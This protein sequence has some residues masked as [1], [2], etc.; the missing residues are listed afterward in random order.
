[1]LGSPSLSQ[2]LTA[3]SEVGFNFDPRT[4]SESAGYSTTDVRHP[5]PAEAPGDPTPGGSWEISR[6]LISDYAFADPSTVRAHYDTSAPL[7][8]R[9]MVLELRALGVFRVF[10]GVRIIEVIDETREVDGRP[11]RVWGWTYGTLR[12]HVES[13]EMSWQTW[14]WLDSGDVEFR[15]HALSRPSRIR[16]PFTAVGFRVV[17][18]HERKTFLHDAGER[19][20]RLIEQRLLGPGTL[21]PQPAIGP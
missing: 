14:K 16:N 7:M 18:P 15:V 2:R 17:G 8:G 19:L 3:L 5:L 10:V 20:N 1:M 21:N 6:G 9:T 11:V 4:L 13:G 12:G